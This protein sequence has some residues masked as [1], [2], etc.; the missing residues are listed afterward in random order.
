MPSRRLERLNEQIKREL[1]DIIR[2]DLRDPRVSDVTVTAV[3]TSPDLAHARVLITT[4][5]PE[6]DRATILAGLDHARPFLRTALS[7]RVRAR[8]TPDLAFEWDAT[9]DHARRIEQ[10]LAQV[11]SNPPA[12]PE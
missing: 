6:S 8:R 5:A 4:L 12:D 7:H 1:M 2:S 3:I 11:R 9:L 10:L